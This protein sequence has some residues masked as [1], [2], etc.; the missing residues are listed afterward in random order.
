M[1]T[2]FYCFFNQPHICWHELQ[3]MLIESAFVVKS[4]KKGY[5][6]I[7]HTRDTSAPLLAI[8]VKDLLPPVE[9]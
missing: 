7:Y 9:K 1:L 3:T 8:G 4:W 5:F 6:N 2:F